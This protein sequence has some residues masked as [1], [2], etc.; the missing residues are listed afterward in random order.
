LK[1]N[2]HARVIGIIGGV[3]CGKSTVLTCL[4]KLY[5]AQLLE[6]DLTARQLMEPGGSCH[7]AVV[8]EWGS[9][10]C[11]PDGRLDRDRLAEIVFADPQQL[12]RLN[13]LVH[14]LVRREIA[15][16]VELWRHRWRK[17]KKTLRVLVLETALPQ[18]AGF[19]GLCDEI[20]YV[21]ADRA[22]RIRRL[23]ESRHYDEQKCLSMMAAQPPEEV[24][25]SLASAVIDNSGLPEESEAQV[26][27]L[28]S[29]KGRTGRQG[30]RFLRQR[31]RTLEKVRNQKLD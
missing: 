27:L 13:A 29:R 25:A 23:M 11:Q 20:W 5:Q 24:Y 28:M 12:A 16:Q 17:E 18:E 3:G 6:S 14:P 8:C 21:R 7:E 26:R 1:R 15:R 10:I 4:Q 22:V 30:N 9:G 2:K 31:R 19:G